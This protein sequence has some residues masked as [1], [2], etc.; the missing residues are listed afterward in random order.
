MLEACRIVPNTIFW[1]VQSHNTGTIREGT[2]FIGGVGGGG[3]AG[4]SEGRVLSNFFTNWE[5][6]NLFYFLHVEGHRF[7]GK[8]KLLHVA[9]ILYIQAKLPVKINLNYLQVSKNL[10]IKKLSSPN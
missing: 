5:G 2:F 3:L 7:F 4:V 10:Y 6:S 1:S 9:S 8:E